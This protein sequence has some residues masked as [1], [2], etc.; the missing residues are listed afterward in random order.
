MPRIT[1]PLFGIVVTLVVLTPG[2]PALADN[3]TGA[4]KLVCAAVHGMI[5]WD[6]GECEEGTGQA[7]NVPQFI[8]IDLQQKRLSTTEASGQNRSTPISNLKREEGQI[9]MQG[10]EGGRA[11]SFILAEE[12]GR[13]SA[14]I[15][16]NGFTVTVFGAC[17]PI[18][19]SR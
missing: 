17:T 19:S 8:E 14:A 15:A 11:F 5:C 7:L 16:V 12:T 4:N 9:V 6:D 13:I 18:S 3:L 10:E 1:R 2:A